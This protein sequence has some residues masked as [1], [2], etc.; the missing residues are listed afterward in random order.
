MAKTNT[1]TAEVT[2][3][4]VATPKYAMDGSDFAGLHET[5]KTVSGVIRFLN[6]EGLTRGEITKV[7]GKRYQHVRN[8]LTQPLKKS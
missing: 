6:S 7:T 3:T 5:H 4:E 2:N 8:V 1:N